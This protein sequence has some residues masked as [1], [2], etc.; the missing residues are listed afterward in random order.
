M[1]MILPFKREWVGENLAVVAMNL[2]FEYYI[3]FES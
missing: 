3:Y 1:R 2:R